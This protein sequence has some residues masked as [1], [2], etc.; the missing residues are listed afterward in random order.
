M[1]A[2][3]QLAAEIRQSEAAINAKYDAEWLQTEDTIRREAAN[4]A[5]EIQTQLA[6]S[7]IDLMKVGENKKNAERLK[8]E[9]KALEEKLRL[10]EEANIKMSDDEVKTV[11]NRIKLL[12]EQIK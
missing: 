1:N 8:L 9:K 6:E 7:E 5:L 4:Q 12:N 2:N 11:E 3:K 10:N